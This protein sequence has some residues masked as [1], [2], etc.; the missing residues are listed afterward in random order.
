MAP[1]R[2]MGMSSAAA[3]FSRPSRALESTR[4]GRLR[5]PGAGLKALR[6]PAE[7]RLVEEVRTAQLNAAVSVAY[8]AAAASL[9]G[10]R[11]L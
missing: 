5:R 2:S 1:A 7:V 9:H 11:F 8:V 3:S 4:Y 6:H 10:F